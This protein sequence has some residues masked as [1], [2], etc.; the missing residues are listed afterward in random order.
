MQCCRAF[1]VGKLLNGF[2]DHSKSST[3]DLQEAIH[4]ASYGHATVDTHTHEI[5]AG[6]L[7]KCLGS[8]FNSTPCIQST[9]CMLNL[10][11]VPKTLF[12]CTDHY[13]HSLT[14]SLTH[15]F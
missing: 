14:H 5:W 12:R 1:S 10:T 11:H 7:A 13:C 2:S 6:K 8:V 9:K 3:T 15:S 4:N